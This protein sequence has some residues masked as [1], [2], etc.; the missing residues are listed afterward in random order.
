MRVPLGT[1]PVDV[2]DGVG[3]H[4][5]AVRWEGIGTLEVPKA[6]VIN[7]NSLVCLVP[8]DEDVVRFHICRMLVSFN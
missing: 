4:I 7:D 8:V 5:T 1:L 2:T 3:Y 6:D